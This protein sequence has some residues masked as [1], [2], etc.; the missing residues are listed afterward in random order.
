MSKPYLEHSGF[1][2]WNILNNTIARHKANVD[3]F[4]LHGPWFAPASEMVGIKTVVVR[5]N[6]SHYLLW[7]LMVLNRKLPYTGSR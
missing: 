5:D 6:S 1:V 3:A 4:A 2:L 7:P